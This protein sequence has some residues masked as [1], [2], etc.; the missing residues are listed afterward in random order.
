VLES[1]RLAPF[2]RLFPM[3][4]HRS[5]PKQGLYI[6]HQVS[7]HFESVACLLFDSG[8]LIVTTAFLS[9]YYHNTW[10]DHPSDNN[11]VYIIQFNELFAFLFFRA[12]HLHFLLFSIWKNNCMNLLTSLISN[13][14]GIL[15]FRH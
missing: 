2:T 10:I 14:E 3:E 4:A 12:N 9:I 1:A 7:S 8:Y 5:C 13:Y 6:V 15:V 11:V